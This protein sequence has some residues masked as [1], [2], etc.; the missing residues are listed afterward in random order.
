MY[1]FKV[2]SLFF[3]PSFF[4]NGIYFSLAQILKLYCNNEIKIHIIL[5]G[6]FTLG[7]NILEYSFF[8]M[9][10]YENNNHYQKKKKR[11]RNN[12]IHILLLLLLLFD[13]LV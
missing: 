10:I 8:S 1:T 9:N 7:K 5:Q 12:L 2:Q 4:T 6:L 13:T 3:L 11:D